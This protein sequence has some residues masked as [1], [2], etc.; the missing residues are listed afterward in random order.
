MLPVCPTCSCR[1]SSACQNRWHEQ[2]E[3]AMPG[4]YDASN[5]IALEATE[6]KCPK[7]GRTDAREGNSRGCNLCYQR[8]ILQGPDLDSDIELMTVERL[9][10]EVKKLRVG[11]RQHRDAIGHNLCWYVP[12]LWDLLPDKIVP[13]PSIPPTDEFLHHCQLYRKSLDK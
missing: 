4:Q 3:M 2:H 13:K 11:I 9:Q 12:E 6:W 5:K 10:A 8:L 7:C 1:G